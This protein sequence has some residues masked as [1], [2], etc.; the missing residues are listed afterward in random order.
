M[1]LSSPFFTEPRLAWLSRCLSEYR[2][3]LAPLKAGIA[4][5][6]RHISPVGMLD[7][8]TASLAFGIEGAMP[9]QVGEGWHGPTVSAAE[10]IQINLACTRWARRRSW[11]LRPN[12]AQ[13][14]PMSLCPARQAANCPAASQIGEATTD[15]SDAVKPSDAS[16]LLMAEKSCRLNAVEPDA[17]G[18]EFLKGRFFTA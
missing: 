16:G 10:T 18:E 14:S 7:V 4:A 9:Q 5:G 15:C 12:V 6:E 2:S 11:S 3:R 1:R 13:C 8:P 17:D